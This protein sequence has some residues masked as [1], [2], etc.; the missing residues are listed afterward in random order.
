ML[1][2]LKK[3][4][5]LVCQSCS[6]YM[7]GMEKQ[8][9]IYSIW[10]LGLSDRLTS[11]ISLYQPSTHL[12]CGSVSAFQSYHLLKFLGRTMQQIRCFFRQDIGREGIFPSCFNLKDLEKAWK[13]SASM[14][15]L[16]GKLEICVNLPISLDEMCHR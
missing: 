15:D 7:L 3:I 10:V 11:T 6:N 16:Y 8:K 2:F 1:F 4:A 14:A 5:Y 9:L 12:I 13:R